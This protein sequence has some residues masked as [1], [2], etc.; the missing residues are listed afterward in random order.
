MHLGRG[1]PPCVMTLVNS[2]Y[3]DGDL[4]VMTDLVERVRNKRYT[5]SVAVYIGWNSLRVML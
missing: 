5:L 1:T 4:F 3:V 2:W